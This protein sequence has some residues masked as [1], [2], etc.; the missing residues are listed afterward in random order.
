[1]F[2]REQTDA[3]IERGLAAL[4][5]KKEPR[6][7]YEPVGYMFGMAGKYLRPRLYLSAFGLFSDTVPDECLSPAMALEMFHEFTLVHDDMMDASPTRRNQPTVHSKWGSNRAILSGDAM[8]ILAYRLLAGC[9]PDKLRGA[10]TLFTDMAIEVCEGQQLDMDFE[11][12]D[13]VSMAEYLEMIG[14]KTGALLACSAA[15][16]AMMAG[17]SDKEVEALSSFGRNIGISFQITDDYLDT[18]GSEESFGKP[19]GGDIANNKKSWLLVEAGSRAAGTGQGKELDA[20]LRLGEADRAGKIAGVTRLYETLG[21]RQGAA[22]AILE[23]H[24]KALE[25]LENGGLDEERRDYMK[26]FAEP[27]IHRE[28]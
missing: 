8:M 7:L 12:R 11:S 23:W 22:D 25:A 10:L 2:T 28:R 27:L 18:F 15:L 5:L 13:S 26:R 1:M 20:L 14:K 4:D 9:P 3:F 6:T 19:I 17:A 16:G 24:D 21:V